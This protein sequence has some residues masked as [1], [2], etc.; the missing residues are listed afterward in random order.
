MLSPEW[1]D[2]ERW[3]L[4]VAAWQDA[5]FRLDTARAIV[6]AKIRN[7]R[8]VLRRH[9]RNHPDDLVT[10]A[11][12]RFRSLLASLEGQHGLDQMR[13]F[14]GQAAALYFGVLGRCVRQEGVAFSGRSRRPPRD[15][16][17]SILSLGYMLL[18]GEVASALA[19]EGLH[20]GL[21]FLHEPS[22]RYQALALDLLEIFRQ[23]VADRLALSLFNRGVLGPS[24][25]QTEG[26]GGVLLKPGSLRRFLSLYE[27][28]LTTPFHTEGQGVTWRLVIKQQASCLR[29]S[30]EGRKAWSPYCWEL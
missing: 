1:G 14:E 4:Q 22:R 21:G 26:S 17:N 23:P 29:D 8:S 13:G 16:V 19:F 6:R 7:Q 11:A 10:R 28:V 3:L 20:P 30:V 5:G 15:P 24:D 2:V 25:F 27:R 18:L 9:A 12:D